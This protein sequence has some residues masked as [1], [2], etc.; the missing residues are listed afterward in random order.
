[1]II[2]VISMTQWDW[3]QMVLRTTNLTTVQWVMVVTGAIFASSWMEA[4]KW[5]R[6]WDKK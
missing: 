1:M 6:I 4:Q 3:L 2:L 5:F